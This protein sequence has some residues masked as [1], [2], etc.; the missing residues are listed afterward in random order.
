MTVYLSPLNI[1]NCTNSH[2]GTVFKLNPDL[3]SIYTHNNN[4]I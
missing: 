1:V 3:E 4:I 2:V